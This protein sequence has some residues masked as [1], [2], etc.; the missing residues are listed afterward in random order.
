MKEALD[1][2]LNFD[3]ADTDK[4]EKSLELTNRALELDDENFSALTHKTT[5]LFRKKDINGLLQTI[6]NLIKLRPEKPYYL[7]QKAIYLELNG[8][9]STAN[10]YYDSALIKYQKHLK[11]DSLDF[12][13]WLEYV[14][15]LEIT[16]DT[17]RTNEILT[18]MDN[19]NF[20]NS[21]KEILSV[22]RT[23][24]HKTQLLSKDKLKK[25]WTGEIGYEQ[26]EEK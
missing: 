10:E 13:L 16:G 4:I 18:R 1:V 21:E 6:D 14:G 2:Y 9:N 20:K 12:N 8:D 15:L 19:T 5:L 22:Y 24:V 11:T 25:Y 26:I 23:Q 17:T 3:L 7:V